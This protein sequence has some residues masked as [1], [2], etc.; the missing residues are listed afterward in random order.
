MEISQIFIIL[1]PIFFVILLGYLAGYFKSL[2]QQH[3]KG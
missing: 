3:L 1:T 2:M